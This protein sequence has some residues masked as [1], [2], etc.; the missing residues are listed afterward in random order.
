MLAA[1]SA[2]NQRIVFSRFVPEEPHACGDG[3]VHA[4]ADL[5]D[6]LA[7]CDDAVRDVCPHVHGDAVLGDDDAGAEWQPPTEQF[8][9][10]GVQ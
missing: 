7:L 3:D 1:S 4:S 9:W 10:P 5:A 2:P 6:G 8:A